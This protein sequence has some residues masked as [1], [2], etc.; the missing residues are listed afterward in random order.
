MVG[1][2][3]LP[4]AVNYF[5]GNDPRHWRTNI[6]TYAKVIGQ[7]VYPGVD[8]VYYGNQQQLEFDFVVAPGA[9]P[10]VIRL[11]FDGTQEVS[12]EAGGALVLRTATGA[13]RWQKPVVYQEVEGDKQAIAGRYVLLGTNQVGFEVAR[14]DA[15][16]PLVIDPVLSYA[17]YLGG[18]GEDNGDSLQSSSIYAGGGPSFSGGIAL[19]N[20]GNVYVTGFT[21]GGFPLPGDTTAGFWDVFVAKLNPTTSTL[22]YVTYIGGNQYDR[23][24]GLAIDAE[25]NVYVTGQTFSPD[26]PTTATAFQPT[27][28]GGEAASSDAFIVKL[29]A[30]GSALLYSTYLGG[31]TSARITTSPSD[32]GYAIAVDRLGNAYVTGA[33][34]STNFP[35]TAGTFAPSANVFAAFFIYDAFVTKLN[36]SQAGVASL[37]Y[38][39]YLGGSFEDEGRGIAVDDLGNAYVTGF[40]NSMDDPNTSVQEVP[41]PTTSNAYQPALAFNGLNNHDAFIT[42]LNPTGS[43]LL[44]S[45]YLGGFADD[46]A[47]GIAIDAERNVYVVGTTLSTNF[48]TTPGAF[49]TANA[50]D[51]DMFVAKLNPSQVGASSLIYATYL[52]GSGGEGRAGVGGIAVDSLGNTSVTSHTVSTDFPTLNA[53]QSTNAGSGD[54]FITKLN[55]SG[56]ALIYS[57]YLGGS[58]RLIFNDTTSIGD[59]VGL[60]IAVDDAGNAYVTGA[61]NSDAFPTTPGAIQPHK[62][63]SPTLSRSFDAF[64]VKIADRPPNR[65]PAADAG[66]DQAVNEGVKVILDG[67]RSSDV[68]GNSLTY[69]WEQIA[70]TSVPLDLRDPVHPTFTAP[71]VSR[72]GET[73]TFRLTVFDG[74][75]TSTPDTVDIT[76]KDVN[77]P[78]V[79]DAGLDKTI[80]EGSPVVLDGSQSFDIDNAP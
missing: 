12:L 76:V 79:A 54:A 1:L 14:Y 30:T 67:S 29:D 44:Y 10:G 21:S 20:D 62:G 64:V 31:S 63:G 51:A 25:R 48:P 69:T 70:G 35:T 72:G 73:L 78:P 15:S 65:S 52:G 26:F 80:Q 41:F 16:K 61:T 34:F 39:T 45:T 49:Q 37:I 66:P 47:F 43:A 75:L 59:D 23:G 17:T 55:A 18:S 58:A 4:G 11:A 60:S 6:P 40:T 71:N 33:T 46:F 3:K 22:I 13:V 9:D 77:H 56:S 50:G 32:I 42:K 5:L 57:S 2:E 74:V 28:P 27:R 24:N 38:S 7:S 68:D 19:D 53:F 36:P 8:V